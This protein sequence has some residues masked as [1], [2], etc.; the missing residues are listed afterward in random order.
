LANPTKP[1]EGV[2]AGIPYL[3]FFGSKLPADRQAE[4]KALGLAPNDWFLQDPVGCQKVSPCMISITP[5]AAWGFGKFDAEGEMLEYVSAA[6]APSKDH[7]EVWTGI[8]LVH[9]PEGSGAFS[10]ARLELKGGGQAGQFVKPDKG[11]RYALAAAE[12][13]EGWSSRG[14][15]YAEAA[16][17]H[18]GWQRVVFRLVGGTEK[19]ESTKN[20]YYTAT[21]TPLPTTPA[22]L[23]ATEEFIKD[24][25]Q[26]KQARDSFESRVKYLRAKVGQG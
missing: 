12:N 19:S 26:V 3:L 17:G 15:N 21:P 11:V 9:D 2:A 7:R 22:Q 20:L 1:E 8:V 5:F 25:S 23:K 13:K 4:L 16:K 6:Q 18:F 24:S 14:P 10:P